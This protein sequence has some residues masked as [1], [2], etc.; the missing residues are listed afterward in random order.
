[1]I[2]AQKMKYRYKVRAYAVAILGIVC[3]GSLIAA[4]LG[5]EPDPECTAET[6]Q[7]SD[8]AA[9]ICDA[10]GLWLEI[11][12]CDETESADGLPWTCCFVPDAGVHACLPADDCEV[13]E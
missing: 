12:D 8:N 3:F 11:A 13:I 5:C 7:C 2:G 1:M 4:V 6:T 9:E 10:D